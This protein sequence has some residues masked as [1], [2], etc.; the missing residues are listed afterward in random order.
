MAGLVAILANVFLSIFWLAGITN[1]LNLLDNM[2]GL[3]SG[4]AAV[5]AGFFFLL[6]VFNGQFLVATLAAALLGAC[7]GFLYYNFNPAKIFMGDSGSLFLGYALAAL[8]IKLRFE[9][10]D[11]VTWM[12][13]VVVLGL[14]IFDTSLVVTS[15]LR[16]GLNPFT[17][18]GKDH[19]S[20]RLVAL[21]WSQR[22]AVLLLYLVCAILGMLAMFLTKASVAEAYLVGA[23]TLLA[24]VFFLVKLEKLQLPDRCEDN[25][26]RQM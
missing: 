11:I 16:R 15:R 13:P 8:G 12:V 2:D 6:A 26:K 18:P 17:T 5:A 19:V 25:K 21:G 14:A 3:S 10:T 24:A 23:A 9:N 22:E 4:I 7:L 20:H 1:S